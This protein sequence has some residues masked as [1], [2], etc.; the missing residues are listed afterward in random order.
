MTSANIMEGFKISGI[1]AYNS[2]IFKES[3]FLTSAVMAHSAAA[4][5]TQ[6]GPSVSESAPSNTH[7]IVLLNISKKSVHPHQQTFHQKVSQLTKTHL[8]KE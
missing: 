6:N 8:V 1:F 4:K 2:H 5:A 7:L 3:Y